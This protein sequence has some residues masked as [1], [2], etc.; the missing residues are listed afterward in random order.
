M[1]STLVLKNGNFILFNRVYCQVSSTLKLNVLK[2]SLEEHCGYLLNCFLKQTITSVFFLFFLNMF[3]RLFKL[4]LHS[5]SI[6]LHVS[7]PPLE[8]ADL[9]F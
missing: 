7:E 2:C 8:A 1:N 5:S 6:L 4:N 9:A 3:Q